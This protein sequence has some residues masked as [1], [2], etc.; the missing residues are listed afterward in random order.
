M[1]GQFLN[2]LIPKYRQVYV[3]VYKLSWLISY[4]FF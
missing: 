3:H 4:I 2:R 1:V